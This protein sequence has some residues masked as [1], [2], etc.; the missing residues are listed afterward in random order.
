[1][2]GNLGLAGNGENWTGG[3]L[4]GDDVRLVKDVAALGCILSGEVAPLLVTGG[5]EL[6]CVAERVRRD[7]RG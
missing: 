6:S 1:V 4:N 2:R 7:L 5:S 3:R